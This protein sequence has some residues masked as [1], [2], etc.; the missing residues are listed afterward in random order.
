M[1]YDATV[2]LGVALRGLKQIP[3]AQAKYEEAM[4]ILPERGDAYYNMGLLYKDFM[5]NDPDPKENKKAYAKAKTYFQQYLGKGQGSA[6]KKEEAKDNIDDCEKTIAALDLA[7]EQMS[8]QPP[9]APA[10]APAPK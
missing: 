6:E 5:T 1:K 8:Q 3:D 4:K 7:I 9:P 2:G 10:P